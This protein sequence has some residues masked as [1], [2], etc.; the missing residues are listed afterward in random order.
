RFPPLRLAGGGDL[1]SGETRVGGKS[2]AASGLVPKLPLS[3]AGLAE[4]PTFGPALEAS[5]R[6]RIPPS[7]CVAVEAASSCDPSRT[8]RRAL[9]SASRPPRRLGA[10][11]GGQAGYVW[12]R[13]DRHQAGRSRQAHYSPPR[14]ASHQRFL[15][16]PKPVRN[17]RISRRRSEE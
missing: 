17:R 6:W 8:S 1:A 14:S 2:V 10:S 9:A 5:S 7:G 16:H 4:W 15:A 12:R 13:R 3:R 11:T